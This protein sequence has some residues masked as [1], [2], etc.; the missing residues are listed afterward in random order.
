MS[1]PHR[2]NSK[3]LYIV[4][5]VLSFDRTDVVGFTWKR[6]KR[7]ILEALPLV[8]IAQYSTLISQQRQTTI[9][10]NI[11]G[12]RGTRGKIQCHVERL[13]GLTINANEAKTLAFRRAFLST[14]QHIRL[15]HSCWNSYHASTVSTLIW[16]R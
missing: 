10:A 7:D 16:Q 9:T 11:A 6:L 2:V 14:H 13:Q 3:R 15:Q 1:L 12:V 5:N 8:A 4:H